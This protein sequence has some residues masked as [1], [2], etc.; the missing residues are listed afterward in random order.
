MVGDGHSTSDTEASDVAPDYIRDP[1]KVQ[2]LR[3]GGQAVLRR[4]LPEIAAGH[5]GADV[6]TMS[7]AGAANGISNAGRPSYSISRLPSPPVPDAR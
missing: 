6:I 4:I 2:L 1:I 5:P 3:T 7:D